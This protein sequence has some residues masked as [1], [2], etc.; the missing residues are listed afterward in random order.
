MKKT[1]KRSERQDKSLDVKNDRPVKV[2]D[3]IDQPRWVH[4]NE[5]NKRHFFETHFLADID[6][7][8]HNRNKTKNHRGKPCVPERSYTG[9]AAKTY[10]KINAKP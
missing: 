10:A 2:L 8:S 3:N 5:S 6:T 7:Y 9:E 4:E 1:E